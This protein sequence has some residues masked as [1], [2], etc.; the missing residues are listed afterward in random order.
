LA[1]VPDK[2]LRELY[3]IGNFIDTFALGHYA[4][5]LE[6]TDKRHRRKVALKIMRPEHL[7]RSGA[8]KWEAQAFVHEADLLARLEQH[9]A[10]MRF[11]D[12]GY[13]SA[14]G[15]YPTTGKIHSYGKDVK[16]FR[17]NLYPSI[18][19]G[20]R[21]YLAL[22]YL[23]RHHSLLY[24]MQPNQPTQR[25]RL[26]TEEG[27]NLASQFAELLQFAHQANIVYLDHKL[28]HIY[29]DGRDLRI[30]DWNSSKLIEAGGTSLE[31]HTQKDLHNL[32]VGVL[33]SIFTGLSPQ[34]G[35]LRP[36]P[37]GQ[38]EVDARYADVKTL[39]FSVEPTLS[40]GIIKLL[41]KGARQEYKTADS[42]LVELNN[43]AVPFGWIPLEQTADGTLRK[44]RLN[45]VEALMKLRLGIDSIREGRE[46][47]LE[48]V[49]L[50]DINE[51][52]EKELRRML[53]DIN[54]FLNA[55]AIP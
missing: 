38:N 50:E 14:E 47:L 11:Y 32:C 25:R 21:P 16:A 42:F 5:V 30:I 10:P 52:L 36:Q 53:K 23:P 12:C 48:A 19:Q 9:P 29:W 2:E 37:A 39:D 55:R 22:E 20:W 45:M 1:S 8:P 13:L 46:L 4:R 40:S 26:P 28:E 33:Y 54:D 31:Q 44:A 34:R 15:E 17:D 49:A 18:A 24:V 51:D 41:E 27:L 43:A 35:G 7:D 3:S 6:A